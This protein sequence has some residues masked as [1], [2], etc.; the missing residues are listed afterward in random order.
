MSHWEGNCLVPMGTQHMCGSVRLQW[1][2]R[3][4]ESIYLS[5]SCMYFSHKHLHTRRTLQCSIHYSLALCVRSSK[6]VF[7]NKLEA[8]VPTNMMSLSQALITLSLALYAFLL[9]P[10]WPWKV[11]VKIG[12]DSSSGS[13]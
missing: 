3:K 5:Y 10:P 1:P 4:T 6:E 11:R 7:S 9:P 12:P 2:L 8:P 13:S